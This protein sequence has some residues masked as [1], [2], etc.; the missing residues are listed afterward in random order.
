MCGIT[1]AAWA[2]PAQ[3]LN[4]ADLG[5]MT[6]VLRHRGPD[7][8]GQYRSEL[9]LHSASGSV[10][11]VALGF[12]RLSIID[13]S[14]GHQ[15]MSNEDSSVWVVFNGEIYNFAA[16][17]KRLEGAG[18]VFR[19]RS[20]TE[21]IVHLYEDEGPD[22]FR[23]LNG[24]F[25]VA[26]WDAARRRLVLGRDRS[27]EK[28]LVYF[29]EPGRIVFASE[30]KSLLEAPGIPREVDPNAIDEYLTY[31]YVPHP[32][33]IFR[34]IRKLP[35]GHYAI[36]SGGDEPCQVHPYWSPDLSVEA[37][38]SESDAIEQLRALLE[39]AVT[40][41]M[42]SE[43]PLGAFLSGGVDS[44]LVTALMQ[45]NSTDR[46]KTFSIGFN[47]KAY[48]ETPFARRVSDHLGTEHQEFQVTPDALEVLPKLAW[49][50]DEPFGDSSAVPTWYLSQ[51][52]RQKVTVALT[53]DGGDELF[54]GYPRYKAAI[55]GARL[56]RMP[57]LR[58]MLAARAWQ[59]LP[60][61]GRQKS[62][63]RKFR[64]FSEA[65]GYAPQRRYL[66]WIAI[67]NECRRAAIYT[68][69]FVGKLGDSDPATFVAD[70]WKRVGKRDAL[71][72]V[73]LADLVTY[74]PCDLMAKVDIASM[75]H[76][77]ES[78]QPFL[79]HRLIEFSIGLPSR[80]KMR[81]GRGKYLL[82]RAFRDLLPPE[83]WSRKKMGFGV[84]LD[85]WFRKELRPMAHDLLLDQT[86]RQRGYVRPEAIEALLREHDSCAF[87][88][89]YR[90]WAL[91]MLELWHRRWADP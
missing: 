61:A 84:P 28:P 89:S 85:R 18:H 88:H 1:G 24:M 45:K 9:R 68:N 15:P 39:S 44:S 57:W 59:V 43:V 48:D 83:I 36:W 69:E 71:T 65:L 21:T 2:N 5:R 4:E 67:F 14:T 37:A 49:H 32:N 66:E 55:W 7:D 90:L 17:R 40:M 53:G 34:G 62:L 23:H 16:L 91:L 77:L 8:V 51:L 46:I 70:A 58:A 19:T 54:A 82:R 73:S 29:P 38:I 56:D 10:P 31:Q 13:L 63:A 22:C 11:G 42:Q 30:L 12:R 87:D 26:I 86:A 76:G 60:G 20:D 27:G 72:A 79:D 81:G 6:D 41:R 74:L 35:P 3:G 47:V 33:T 78:R 25:A 50:Y 52:T 75:A 80:F 64:R